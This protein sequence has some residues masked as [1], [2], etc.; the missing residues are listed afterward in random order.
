MAIALKFN[1]ICLPGPEDARDAQAKD[2]PDP[3]DR[4]FVH[5]DNNQV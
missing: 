3:M 1:G 5:M 4:A 2:K